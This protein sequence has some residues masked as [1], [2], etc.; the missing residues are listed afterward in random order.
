M[1]MAVQ[2]EGAA[3]NTDSPR[4]APMRNPLFDIRPILC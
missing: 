1:S 4:H 3:G 2:A